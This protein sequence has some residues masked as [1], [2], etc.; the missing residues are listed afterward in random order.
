MRGKLSDDSP[1][2]RLSSWQTRRIL[3]V[4]LGGMGEGGERGVRGERGER[5]ERG[6]RGVG[7]VGGERFLM[8]ECVG[9]DFIHFP[10]FF[11]ICF[12]ILFSFI[13]LVFFCRI[14]RTWLRVQRKGRRRR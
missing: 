11:L 4:N 2:Q 7:G 9:V 10:V 13:Y 6:E 12:Y 5:R 1:L 3:K 8:N 14:W